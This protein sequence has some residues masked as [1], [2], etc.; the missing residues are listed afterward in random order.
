MRTPLIAVIIPAFRQPVLLNEA[1]NSALKGA[2]N[3]AVVV[4]NDGCPLTETVSVS[5]AWA[6]AYPDSVFL[7]HTENG[8]LSA[9]RNRGIRFALNRWPGVQAIFF[10]D[11]DNRLTPEAFP[12]FYKLLAEHSEYDWFYPQFDMFGLEKNASHGGEYSVLLHSEANFCEA[13]SLV[14]RHVFDQG[15]F[16]DERMRQ[17]YEDWDFWLRCAKEGFRGKACNERFLAYRRRPQSMLASSHTIDSVLRS[18]I[19]NNHPWLYA[20]KSLVALEDV[21]LPRYRILLTDTREIICATDPYYDGV[22]LTA[23]ELDEQFWKTV[24]APH[25]YACGAIWVAL[26]SDTLQ[27]LRNRGLVRFVFWDLERRLEAADMAYFKFRKDSLRGYAYET[28]LSSPSSNRMLRSCDVLALKWE[29]IRNAVIDGLKRSKVKIDDLQRSGAVIIG[30][31]QVGGRSAF[32]QNARFLSGV[33]QSLK[34]SPYS[35]S[36]HLQWD[37]RRHEF[38][39]RSE[40]YKIARKSAQ[41]GILYPANRA[42]E[43][44]KTI[45][46]F[47]HIASFGGVETVAANVAK[48]LKKAGFRTAICLGGSTRIA[49]SASISECFDEIMWH[50]DPSY[51]D[52][53]GGVYTGT[54]LPRPLSETSMA[55]LT[56]LLGS[57]D[58]VIACHAGAGVSVFSQLRRMGVVTI[59]HEHVMETSELGLRRGAPMAAVAYEAAADLILSC[60]EGL[61]DWLHG[62]GVP[63]EKLMAIPNAAGFESPARVAHT[64]SKVPFDG[65]RR[66]RV[67]YM[68]RLDYQ[69][70]LDRLETII[71]ELDVKGHK[72]D[73]KI[74]G[75]AVI[76]DWDEKVSIAGIPIE[77]PVFEPA[78]KSNLLE[79]ADILVLP[80][81]FEGVPL[82]ILEAQQ[83]GVVAIATD[84][85]EVSEAIDHCETGLLASNAN[86]VADMVQY[87]SDLAQNPDKLAEISAAAA[88]RQVTWDQSVEPMARWLHEEVTKRQRH[89]RMADATALSQAQRAVE[90]LISA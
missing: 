18:T 25:E 35:K 71:Q 13:G 47:L 43:G 85:G 90:T 23:G 11:A 29:N 76:G 77:P 5:A 55:E 73:W 22:R 33:L 61:R 69:K 39:N 32:N 60:S 44:R 28:I 36:S 34:E 52:W 74:V 46:F 48:A 10:L 38:A 37:W 88:A 14:R 1:I 31:E 30:P 80:S 2:P 21:E 66:L 67:L 63:A 58:V 57:F 19:R 70:G 7:V 84:V 41:T 81:R 17:G 79:W 42:R 86:C 45:C 54:Y 82:M 65:K 59:F 50:L 51:A 56:G 72:I 24:L 75:K 49:L 9:A 87:I 83:H 26:R 68:G 16:F 20:S 3:V 4:V 78:E 64:N 12:V 8:G 40:G 27:E 89:H 6:S 53:G 15:V 62:Q